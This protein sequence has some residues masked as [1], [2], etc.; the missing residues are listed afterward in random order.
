[1]KR[2]L[3]RCAASAYPLLPPVTRL[4][5][6]VVVLVFVVVMVTYGYDVLATLGVVGTVF[7]V[8]LQISHQIL[9]PLPA[10]PA[11]RS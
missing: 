4:V 1:M 7:A 5:V 11:P 10:S 8:A 3:L 6:L 9:S 2:S